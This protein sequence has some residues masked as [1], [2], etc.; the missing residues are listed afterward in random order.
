MKSLIF[1]SVILSITIFLFSVA[2]QFAQSQ[3]HRFMKQHKSHFLKEHLKQTED[4]LVK[5]L[6]MNSVSL[7]ST[8]S[9]TIRELEQIF[10]DEPFNVFIEPLGKI[11]KDEHAEIKSRIL[12]AL[13]LD[14]LHSDSGD[15]VIYEVAKATSDNSLKTICE[16][17]A[18]E[19]F[20]AEEKISLK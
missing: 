15:K 12:S 5:A 18:V 8:A 11:I 16:A 1:S 17:L 13:A 14:G 19:S 7:N 2:P 10:P 20:K 6:E 4:M 3:T 9:Q